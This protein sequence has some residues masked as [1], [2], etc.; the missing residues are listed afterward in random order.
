MLLHAYY[1]A[2]ITYLCLTTILT[3]DYSPRIQSLVFTLLNP[4]LNFHNYRKFQVLFVLLSL[5]PLLPSLTFP[6]DKLL[7]LPIGHIRVGTETK[8]Y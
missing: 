4:V 6:I 7:H 8:R 5:P 1:F 3:T 2:V